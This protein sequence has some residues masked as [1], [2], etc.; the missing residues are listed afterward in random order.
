VRAARKVTLGAVAATVIGLVVPITSATADEGDTFKGG[1][2]LSIQNETSGQN[3]GVI[4]DLSLSQEASAG[5]SGATVK[6][7]IEVN[8]SKAPGTEVVAAGTGV[9]EGEAQISYAAGDTDI[10][11]LCQQVTFADGSTWVGPDGTN[12]GLPSRAGDSDP[13]AG[14]DRR[15]Q[16]PLLHRLQ[17]DHLRL[18]RPG[19]RGRG[20]SGV[21][22]ST[23][24][25]AACRNR[26]D[27]L[28][29]TSES[30]CRLS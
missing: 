19:G 29:I 14:R 6:C 10:V 11:A 4:A 12:P 20:E 1:C 13:A 30:L 7:W 21:A 28:F 16:Q 26:T 2:A 22:V 3:Q 18:G 8:G 25:G 23:P 9:Q 17:P 27:D 5:P 15:P 24:R